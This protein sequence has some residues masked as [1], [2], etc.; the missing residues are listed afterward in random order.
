MLFPALIGIPSFLFGNVLAIAAMNSKSEKTRASGRI[1]LRIMWG[2]V[3]VYIVG[4][5]VV[6]FVLLI[7]SNI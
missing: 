2:L 1:A 3:A 6:G 7:R 4:A 5:L